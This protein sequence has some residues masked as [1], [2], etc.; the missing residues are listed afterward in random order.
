LNSTQQRDTPPPTPSPEPQEDLCRPDDIDILQI[1]A[2]PSRVQVKWSFYIEKLE[3]R[4][5][6]LEKEHE[7]VLKSY[8]TV[9]A[10][11]DRVVKRIKQLEARLRS[12]GVE[13]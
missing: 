11:M 4:V 1:G 13:P 12:M 9:N 8:R 7:D 2:A 6:N 10:T 5:A 3:A